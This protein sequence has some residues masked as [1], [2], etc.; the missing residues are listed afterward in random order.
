MAR[1]SRPLSPATALG[2]GRRG[3][4]PGSP[5]RGFPQRERPAFTL[6]ELLVVIAIIAILAAILFPVFAKAREKARQNACLSNVKQQVLGSLQYAQDYDERFVLSYYGPTS[7]RFSYMQL[8]QPYIKSVQIY[9]CPSQRV[10]SIL[11]YAGE[12]SY[13]LNAY[14]YDQSLAV[15]IALGQWQAPAEQYLLAETTPNVNLAPW[16]FYRAGR[17]HRPDDPSG[18]EYHLW[19]AGTTPVDTG[20]WGYMNLAVRHNQVGNIGF[21]DGHAKALTYE[22]AY[23]QKRDDCFDPRIRQ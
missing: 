8:I 12:R 22:V 23:N 4:A 9:D 1:C 17:G 5:R 3:A 7:N 19:N 11:A 13:G 21:I 10:K 20:S 2:A 14:V 15:G 18:A 16:Q 6:I